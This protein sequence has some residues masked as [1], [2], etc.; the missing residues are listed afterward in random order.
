MRLLRWLLI[1]VGVVAV[2]YGAFAVWFNFIRDD[3]ED[4][5]TLDATTTT[6]ADAETE[7]PETTT[8]V[9]SGSELDGTWTVTAGSEAGY[10]AQE[11][12]LGQDGE[13]TGR[14]TS[15]SGEMT[16]EGTSVPVATITVDMASIESSESRRDDQFRGRIMD[17]A[18]F[19]TS[20]FVLTR[21]IELEPLPAVG[22]E[23]TVAATGDLTL[24]GT[25]MPVTI[26]IQARR[27]ADS[28]EIAG[29]TEIVFD[30]WNIPEPSGGPAQVGDVGTL[31]FHLF[32]AR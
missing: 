9:S 31:E 28:I 18:S 17:V 20:T 14:T 19:P 26:D 10:R 27:N 23:R 7:T 4:P 13:A 16:I 21:P 15:V 8:T 29:S 30:A 6:V 22:E 1:I 32:F 2:A 3:A 11:I 12:V 5:F 25:T 24:R